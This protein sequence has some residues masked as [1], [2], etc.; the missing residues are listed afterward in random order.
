MMPVPL[1]VLIVEDSEDDTLLLVE[2][3]RAGGFAP[4]YRRV[5]TEAAYRAAL[6]EECWEIVIADYVLP[7]FSGLAALQILRESGSDIPLIMVSG[8]AG[9]ETA[10][11]AM[12]A[13][14]QDYLLKGHLSRLAPA[15]TRDL[16]E[17]AGRRE[18][19]R[20]EEAERRLL[21]TVG[22]D[23]RAPATLINGEVQ[24][25]LEQL[26]GCEMPERIQPRITALRQALRR[27]FAMIDDLTELA[28]LEEGPLAL[29]TEPLSLR[30]YLE[31]LLQRNA[32]LL[33]VARIALDIPADLPPLQADP[34]YL[35]RILQNFLTN[36]QKYSAPATPIRISAHR[37]EDT[38]V[39]AITD[40]GQ[41]I[42]PEDLPHL[43]DRFYRT[44]RGR[45]AESLGLGLYIT[46]RL[47]EAH[48]GR[49]WVES[50]VGK[51]STFYFTLPL[52][53]TGG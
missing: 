44:T 17:A 5:E 50:E 19:R 38:V 37:E 21:Y 4:S 23:L 27:M 36:A 53:Q 7:R 16:Q 26:H 15:I 46:K 51:G 2:A 39:I 22:H 29:T 11:E 6:A 12:H 40:Q 10:V 48:G 3:L 25:L 14:A 9:E 1:R 31:E 18:R 35:A 13:G 8:K 47:V 42:A 43:F 28:Q 33:D 45:K 49:M 52:A 32:G 20:A 30:P 34:R 41:G 24:L